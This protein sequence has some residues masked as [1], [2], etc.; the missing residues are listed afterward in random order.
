[1]C[2]VKAFSR[3]SFTPNVLMYSGL[4]GVGEAVKAINENL[5][6]CGYVQAYAYARSARGCARSCVYWGARW[7]SG[8]E[9]KRKWGGVKVRGVDPEI[10]VGQGVK[11]EGSTNRKNLHAVQKGECEGKREERSLENRSKSDLKR[12]KAR[13]DGLQRAKNES[14]SS[15]KCRKLSLKRERARKMEILERKRRGGGEA[16]KW[17]LL[18]I[19]QCYEVAKWVQIKFSRIFFR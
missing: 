6:T 17:G 9:R 15:K 5:L 2:F 4:R 14:D 16:K 12:E 1:M 8:E 3:F 11:N 10:K 7:K 13:K 18:P 19:L